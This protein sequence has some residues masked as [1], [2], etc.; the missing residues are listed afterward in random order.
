MVGGGGMRAGEGRSHRSCF[1]GQHS[2]MTSASWGQA[3][4]WGAAELSGERPLCL[5]FFQHTLSSLA[6]GGSPLEFLPSYT[7]HRKLLHLCLA[8]W[9]HVGW[10]VGCP[11][12]PPALLCFSVHSSSQEAMGGYPAEAW[13]ASPP[14]TGTLL[15]E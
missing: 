8:R 12:L 2:L 13:G 11:A 9:R 15:G 10:G 14:V 4:K 1:L 7:S 5:D 3:S 6:P